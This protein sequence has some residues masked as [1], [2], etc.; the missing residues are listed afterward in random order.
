[1]L[2]LPIVQ[3]HVSVIKRGALLLAAY[4][5]LKWDCCEG[6]GFLNLRNCDSL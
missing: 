5:R 6:S 4:L 1:M 3:A 2:L